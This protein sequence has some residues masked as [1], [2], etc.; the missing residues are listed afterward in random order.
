MSMPHKD[1]APTRSHLHELTFLVAQTEP[2]FACGSI[3]SVTSVAVSVFCTR[4]YPC[5]MVAL[6][7]RISLDREYTSLYDYHTTE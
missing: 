6:C 4:V 3:N 1:L 7:G 5:R 2:G